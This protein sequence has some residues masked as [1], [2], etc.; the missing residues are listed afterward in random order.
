MVNFAPT[1]KQKTVTF[2]IGLKKVPLVTYKATQDK[3]ELQQQEAIAKVFPKNQKI[4]Q[5]E[6]E[7]GE[8]LQDS[9]GSGDESLEE[10]TGESDDDLNLKDEYEGDVVEDFEFSSEE[11]ESE[12]D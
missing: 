1:D 11:E 8:E 2:S 4:K 3:Y 5:E 10:E 12:A 9:Y 7:E 6:G